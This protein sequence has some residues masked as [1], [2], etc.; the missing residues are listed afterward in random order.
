MKTIVK[1]Y[2]I[3]LLLLIAMT[4]APALAFSQNNSPLYLPE[5]FTDIGTMAAAVVAI[6]AIVNNAINL[7]GFAKQLS[8][9]AI[10]LALAFIGWGL[11]AK[12][13]NGLVWYQVLVTG[14]GVGLLANGVFD[15]PAVKFI[16]Q[17]LRIEPADR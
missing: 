3:G 17:K 8:S 12:I 6:A 9:W 16:L 5:I 4:L 1:N 10:S 7:K 14:F 15:M 13:F 11:G 2:R